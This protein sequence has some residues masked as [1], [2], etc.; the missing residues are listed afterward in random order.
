MDDRHFPKFEGSCSKLFPSSVGSI[1]W[2]LV[3]LLASLSLRGLRALGTV[4]ADEIDG[5]MGII[6]IVFITYC[7]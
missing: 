1:W 5:R 4:A 6:V 3:A 7:L 2:G